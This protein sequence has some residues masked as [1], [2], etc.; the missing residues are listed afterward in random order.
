M[1]EDKFR[2]ILAEALFVQSQQLTDVLTNNLTSKFTKMLDDR[3]ADQEQRLEQNLNRTL[4]RELVKFFGHMSRRIAE[5]KE[6]ILAEVRAKIDQL[7]I[8]ID[9][10]VNRTLTYEQEQAAIMHIQ[11]RHT[12]WI[13]QLAVAAKTNL[14]S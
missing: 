8:T 9:G 2:Q 6:E 12:R 4:D 1:T 7:I 11:N 14:I 3:L 5:N 10:V 13:N